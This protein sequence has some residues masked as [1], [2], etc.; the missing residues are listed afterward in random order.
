MKKPRFV[1]WIA[2][3]ILPL[4]LA[5]CSNDAD[6]VG[7]A[8]TINVFETHGENT[9][10]TRGATRTA[11]R[12]GFRLAD[13]DVAET[14]QASNIYLLLNAESIMKMD[15]RSTVEINRV[16]DNL[17]SLTL[18]EGAVAADIKRESSDD[19]YEIHVG[20]IM[21][22]V[23]GTSFIMEYR[24]TAPVIVMLE[25]S[26]EIGGIILEAGEIAVIDVTADTVTV[27]PFVLENLDSPF[28]ASEIARREGNQTVYGTGI[29]IAVVQAGA[30]HNEAAVV[31]EFE[32]MELYLYAGLHDDIVWPSDG[33]Y[34][35]RLYT[36]GRISAGTMKE[37][38]PFIVYEN[39]WRCLREGC[40]TGWL[41]T[42][43]C[44]C[45]D[46]MESVMRVWR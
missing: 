26:G 4:F 28:I 25:G 33:Y 11:P 44:P 35:L 14:G 37:M 32:L 20:N 16:S 27:E 21:M 7:S 18:V 10:I 38:F 40:L 39:E 30:A 34:E 19:I 22:G 8:R 3:I 46:E 23:R 41:G 42:N 5:A 24:G 6:V 29:R 17:L 36:D 13:R 2:A 45:V 1:L 43:Q 9:S 12:A 15:E 31:M